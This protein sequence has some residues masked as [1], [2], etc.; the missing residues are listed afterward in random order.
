M[1]NP[2][3]AAAVQQ[4]LVPVQQFVAMET[5]VAAPQPAAVV[6]APTLEPVVVAPVVVA[7]VVVPPPVVPLWQTAMSP[8][9]REYYWNTQTREVSWTLPTATAPKAKTINTTSADAKG[10]IRFRRTKA[11]MEAGKCATDRP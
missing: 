2:S 4:V 6:L 8:D 3:P 10:D 11:E 5:T 9:G 7:A 1:S